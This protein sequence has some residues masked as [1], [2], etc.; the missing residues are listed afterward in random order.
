MDY[1]EF[2]LE[3]QT[4][5]SLRNKNK[6]AHKLSEIIGNTYSA[7][8]HVPLNGSVVVWPGWLLCFDSQ[9]SPGVL[10]FASAQ[11]VFLHLK[12]EPT[13][14]YRDHIIRSEG[15]MQTPLLHLHMSWPRDTKQPPTNSTTKPQ[16]PPKSPSSMILD[17]SQVNP[18][19][20]LISLYKTQSNHRL[21]L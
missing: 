15:W 3:A 1:R 11:E 8:K 19:T 17:S 21:E 2:S 9:L 12:H 5:G 7:K 6:F 10:H 18:R 4:D 13:A 14:F 16:V 20:S